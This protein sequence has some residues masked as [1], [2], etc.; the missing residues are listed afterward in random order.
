MVIGYHVILGAYGFWLPN[1]PR[2]SWSTFVWAK[3]LRRFGSA[4]KVSTRHSVA[5]RAHDHE[6]RIAAREA[7][8]YPP[9]KFSGLQ[10]RTIIDGF[11]GL[12][13][14]L[15]LVV[16]ACAIMP[17]HVHLVLPRRQLDIEE[18]SEMLKRAG[19]RR[20]NKLRLNPMQNYVRR[21]GRIPSLWAD[22]GWVVFIDAPPQMRSAIEY[23]EMNPL[24]A[25]LK[26]QQWSFVVPYIG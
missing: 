22:K 13:E 19:T 9:V 6:A 12:I 2:G 3:H 10:A 20:L 18:V 1:D 23:V 8:R 5:A 15:Q 11:A 26:R 4:T 25:G 21:N 17:D 16:H 7:L 24:K 14:K